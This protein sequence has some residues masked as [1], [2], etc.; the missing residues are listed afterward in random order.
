MRLLATVTLV[1]LSSA[2]GVWAECRCC[3][4]LTPEE[5][6]AR[7]DVVLVGT[8]TDAEWR[9]NVLNWTTAQVRNWFRVDGGYYI[10]PRVKRAAK[11]SVGTVLKG[12]VPPEVT[13]HTY[14][15][16]GWCGLDLEVGQT[17]LPGVC[18]TQRLAAVV[19]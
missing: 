10:A 15:S 1:L 4:N 12:E 9:W 17:Y 13:V 19:G 14:P 16:G 7:A 6:M 8:V 3:D 5:A 11:L 18:G 2:A